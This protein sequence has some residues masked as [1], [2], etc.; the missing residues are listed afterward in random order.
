VNTSGRALVTTGT[1]AA[2]MLWD[3]IIYTS[4]SYS[5]LLLE[6]IL[7]QEQEEQRKQGEQGEQEEL[8]SK[9]LQEK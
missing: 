1:R 5:N 4:T 9:R 3:W 6:L 8:A 2:G 7:T